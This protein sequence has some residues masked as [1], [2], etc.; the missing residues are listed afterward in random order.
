M[1]LVSGSLRVVWAGPSRAG[2]AGCAV[3]NNTACW[4]YVHHRFVYYD[5]FSADGS[6]VPCS[7]KI[8]ILCQISG[9]WK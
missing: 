2:F 9:R 6:K 4:M 7:N 5:S 1:L 3:C 8:S